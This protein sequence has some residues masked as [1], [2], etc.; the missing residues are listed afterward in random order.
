MSEQ[1]KK[2]GRPRKADNQA[3][4]Q[5]VEQKAMELEAKEA[6]QHELE[7]LDQNDIAGD[8]AKFEV[9]NFIEMADRVFRGGKFRR[10]GWSKDVRGYVFARRGETKLVFGDDKWASYYQPSQEDALANDWIEII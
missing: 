10:L 5:E 1:Q 9:L 7:Q 3:V 4:E 2:R 8:D 6:V